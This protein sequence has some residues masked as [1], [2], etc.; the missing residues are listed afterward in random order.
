MAFQENVKMAAEAY[1]GTTVTFE[2]ISVPDYF[3]DKQ[4]QPTMDPGIKTSRSGNLLR[5]LIK[6]MQQKINQFFLQ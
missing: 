4:L 6:K 5:Q 1:D 3:S 2:V